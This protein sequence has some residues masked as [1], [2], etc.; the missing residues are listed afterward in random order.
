VV[1]EKLNQGLSNRMNAWVTEQNRN[2]PLRR[3]GV[4]K[5]ALAVRNLY[6]ELNQMSVRS[7]YSASATDWFVL[8]SIAPGGVAG[9]QAVSRRA[10]ICLGIISSSLFDGGVCEVSKMPF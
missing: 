8:S 10:I 1:K 2:F 5:I 7:I 3:R 4:K 6:H 9:Q